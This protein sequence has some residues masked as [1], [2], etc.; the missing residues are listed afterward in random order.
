MSE[1]DDDEL[2]R[3]IREDNEP[4][5]AIVEATKASLDWVD[6]DIELARMVEDAAVRDGLRGDTT[7]ELAIEGDGW[8]IEIQTDDADATIDGLIVPPAACEVVLSSRTAG[9]RSTTSD[10]AGYFRFD[11]MPRGPM[12]LV[13]GPPV[14]LR[15]VTFLA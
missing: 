9:R 7:V 1:L 15:T 14:D 12:R 4:P 3:L 11:D 2:G 8:R 5:A 6:A 10:D 13:F